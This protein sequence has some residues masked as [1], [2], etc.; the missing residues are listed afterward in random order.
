MTSNLE[1]SLSRLIHSS[2]RAKRPGFTLVEL[3]TT[4]G[5]IG[6]LI[7][8]LLPAKRTT[9]EA[10]RRSQCKNNLKQIG[11]ALHNYADHYGAL[12][13]AYT[14]DSHGK[15][16]HSWR[17]LILP[18]VDQAPLYNRINLSKAWDDPAN[19]D[20]SKTAIAAFQCPS[21]TCAAN[22]TTYMAIVAAKGCF[23]LN[24]PRPLSEITD[25]RGVTLMVIEVDPEHAV[26]WM[27]PVDADERLLLSIGAKTKLAHTGGMHS[28]FVDGQ[29][30]FLSTETSAET[31][32][33]L[34]SIAGNEVMASAQ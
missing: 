12:P 9:R 28:T 21:T 23:S 8:L 17:T 32:R 18:Y 25:G 15:P 14:V 20:A 6:I 26:H 29:V 10:A 1:T 34:I 4:I 19:A 22:H 31:R 5:I 27:A 11:L 16:L 24:E 3:L 13:P 33:A 7:A 2:T 30:R